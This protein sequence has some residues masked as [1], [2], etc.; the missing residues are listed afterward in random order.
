MAMQHPSLKTERA[1]RRSSRVRRRCRRM[2]IEDD[3]S[4]DAGA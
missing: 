4:D 1:L 2:T 3:L